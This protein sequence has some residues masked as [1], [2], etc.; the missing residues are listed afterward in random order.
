MKID[1]RYVKEKWD[2]VYKKKG[3][4]TIP[5]EDMPKIVSIFKKYGVKRILDLGC[6]SGRHTIYLSSQGFDVWGI[7]ISEEACKITKSQLP[8]TDTKIVC[9]SIYKR[10][11]YE[12]NFFDAVISIQTLH[13]ANIGDIQKAIREIERVLKPRGL[14][15]VTVRKRIQ[16]R[17]RLPF[18]ELEPRVYIPIEGKEKGLI[19][20]LFNKKLLRKEFRDFKIH[21]IWVD[22]HSYYCLLG[23]LDEF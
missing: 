10:L 22:S 16:K 11:P 8:S 6:G 15:F 18:Q 13:H 3:M 7:D 14:V 20:Y 12:D 23:E 2:E 17:K 5:H 19:H 21:D 1:E 4:T 9:G